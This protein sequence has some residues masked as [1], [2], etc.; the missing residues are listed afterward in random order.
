MAN[1]QKKVIFA[2][3]SLT[4]KGVANFLVILILL[5]LFIFIILS[6]YMYFKAPTRKLRVIENIEEAYLSEDG[7]SVY[8][9]LAE[10]SNKI[11]ATKIKFILTNKNGKEYYYETEKTDSEF[12]IHFRKNLWQWLFGLDATT[13]KYD[14]QINARDLKLADFRNTREASALLKP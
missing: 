3:K 2:K 4:K 14:Y 1:T 6:F 13:K 9:K 7:K 8:I 11:N 5:V 10:E 12:S